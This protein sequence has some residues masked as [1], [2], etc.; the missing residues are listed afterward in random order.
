MGLNS[1]ITINLPMTFSLLNISSN[2]ITF[3]NLSY[4]HPLSCGQSSFYSVY[5]Y[6][7]SNQNTTLDQV[8]PSISCSSAAVSTS[9][10]PYQGHIVV[11][12]PLS[13]VT[14]SPLT[15]SVL[16]VL[17]VINGG[18]PTAISL[19]NFSGDLTQLY[20]TT[21]YTISNVSV[22]VSQVDTVSSSSIQA[23]TFGVSY[24][25]FEIIPLGIND[26]SIRN[27]TINFRV[28][29]SWIFSNHLNSLNVIL[30]RNSGTGWTPLQTVM[31]SNDS[32]Y[33]YYTA[34]SPGFSSYTIFAPLISQTSQNTKGGSSVN[35]NKNIWYY[36]L[37]VLVIFVMV[38]VI[39][40]KLLQR[41]RRMLFGRS[42]L[43]QS[44]KRNLKRFSVRKR[45]A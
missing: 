12:S 21:D 30:F 32:N 1:N 20:V 37:V 39:M 17:P 2:S 28:N 6:T 33:Y 29:S 5:N 38:I 11:N 14:N 7:T 25:S 35:T 40:K 34:V 3:Y 42:Y 41:K 27:T 15:T 22:N 19:S 23:N 13:T 9:G 36:I 4:T 45:K 26:S 18:Q 44:Q 10:Y 8:L 43:L 24:Q 31:N 16:Q